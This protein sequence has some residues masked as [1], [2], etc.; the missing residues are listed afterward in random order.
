[1]ES[2]LNKWLKYLEKI[3]SLVDNQEL[4]TEYQKE[5]I[6]YTKNMIK[7]LEEKITENK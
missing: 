7:K 6:E 5:D 1:M 4:L 2:E 3:E